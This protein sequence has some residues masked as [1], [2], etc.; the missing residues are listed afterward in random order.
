MPSVSGLARDQ[1]IIARDRTV[2]AALLTLGQAPQLHYTQDGRRW[3]GIAK[4]RN[5]QLG[6]FPTHS[7]CSS[8]ATWCLW[9]GLQ[10]TFG[11]ADIVNGTGWTS[12]FTGSMLQHGRRVRHPANALKGDCVFYGS[13]PPGQHVTIVVG[14]RAGVPWV[15][16]HGSEPGPFHVAYDYREDVLQIRRY[17]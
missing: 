10:L 2:Q 5:A 11:I 9:N 4:R 1:R 7:D 16:S 13:G 14:R 17:I 6:Q 8:F 3:D 12:G 15:V